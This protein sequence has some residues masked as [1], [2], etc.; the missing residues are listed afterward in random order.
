MLKPEDI[1]VSLYLEKL[2]VHLKAVATIHDQ[3]IHLLGDKFLQILT[4]VRIWFQKQENLH[5]PANEVKR[6]A[7]G[8]EPSRA[9]DMKR[10]DPSQYTDE[11]S[12]FNDFS[13]APTMNPTAWPNQSQSSNGFSDANF[14]SQPSWDDVAFDFPMD[15]DPN[16]FTHLMQADETQNHQYGEMLTGETFNQMDYLNNIPNFGSWPVQ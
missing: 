12:L 14:S 10:D 16:L 4:K 2:L 11:F 8:L 6:P 9:M 1:K 3:A 13:K 7:A 5:R 15:L